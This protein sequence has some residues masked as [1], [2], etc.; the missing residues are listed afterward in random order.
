MKKYVRRRSLAP[1]DE[2]K[3]SN[4]RLRVRF[5]GE[6]VV[7]KVENLLGDGEVGQGDDLTEEEHLPLPQLEHEAGLQSPGQKEVADQRPTLHRD[8]LL[9]TL[10]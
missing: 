3:V 10:K 4:R 6:L 8:R 7:V 5:E 9:L 1:G 2:T